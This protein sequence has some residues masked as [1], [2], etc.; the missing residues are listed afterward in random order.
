M[1][2][3]IAAYS[4]SIKYLIQNPE[5]QNRAQKAYE[6][7]LE[8]ASQAHI[9]PN[10]KIYL[11]EAIALFDNK[12]GLTYAEAQTKPVGFLKHAFILAYYSMLKS[13]DIPEDELY[14]FAMRQIVGLGG[15]T[16]TNAAIAG[17]M[18][19]AYVGVSKLP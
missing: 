9:D 3:I 15:D 14:D 7:A 2:N 5:D 19:G 8:Y 17:G 4:I 18:I 6:I 16:D 10:L 1:H 13:A 12:S 11:Q